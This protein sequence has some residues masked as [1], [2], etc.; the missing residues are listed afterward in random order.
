MPDILDGRET[1]PVQPSRST[2]TVD[3]TEEVDE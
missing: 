3:D 1:Y 2:V